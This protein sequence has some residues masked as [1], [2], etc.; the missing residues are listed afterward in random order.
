[1]VLLLNAVTLVVLVSGAIK[2]NDFS[3]A[4]VFISAVVAIAIA[5]PRSR[6]AVALAV[7][8][9]SCF[10]GYLWRLC[11]ISLVV[12][13]GLAVEINC[14]AVVGIRTIIAI[15]IGKPIGWG[16]ITGAIFRLA[17]GARWGCWRATWG[18]LWC[19]G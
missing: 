9:F 12:V 17:G 8:N 3:G 6:G 13:E 5:E 1:M 19:G 18:C 7:D 2:V 10:T 16:T 14:I 11:A 15:T 4:F